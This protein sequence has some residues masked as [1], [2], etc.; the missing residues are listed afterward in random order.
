M[1]EELLDERGILI[2]SMA[3]LSSRYLFGRT[4]AVYGDPDMVMAY[5]GSYA[6]LESH[7]SMPAPVLIM[8]SSRR[9]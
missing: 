1:S 6:N 9:E 7:H 2:D 3:D 4:A 8:N 5:Q